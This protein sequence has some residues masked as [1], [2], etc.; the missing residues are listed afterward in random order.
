[1][2]LPIGTLTLAICMT[3]AGLSPALYAHG[4]VYVGPGI[5]RTPPSVPGPT[6]PPGSGARGGATPR[7]NPRTTTAIDERLWETWWAFNKE[8]FFPSRGI[9]QAQLGGEGYDEN[10]PRSPSRDQVRSTIIPVLTDALTSDEFEMRNSAVIALGKVGDVREFKAIEAMLD[11]DDRTVVEA[12]ILGLGLLRCDRA[13]RRLCEV[14]KE[15]GR[16]ARQRGFAV[17]ALG[18]SG[19]EIARRALIDKIGRAESTFGRRAR[20]ADLESLRAVAAGLVYRTDLP[21]VA[22]GDA[23]EGVAALITAIR[24]NHSREKSFLPLAFVGLAKTRDPGARDIVLA[25]LGHRKSDVRGAAAIAL[26]RVFRDP[27]VGLQRRIQRIYLNERDAFVQRLMLISLGRMGG[28]GAASLLARERRHGDRQQRAFAILGSAILGDVAVVPEFRKGL[29]TSNDD[30]LRG[31]FAIAIGILRDRE[32]VPLILQQIEANKSPALRVHLI[33][34]LIL[35]GDRSAAPAVEELLAKTRTVDLQ[36]TAALALGLLGA[37]DSSK[38][39]LQILRE[40]GTVT[41]K[42][43]VAAGLGRMGEQKLI[44]PLIAFVKDESQQDLSRAFGLIALGMMGEKS[45]SIP[46]FARVAIDSQYDLQIDT[47]A[48]LRDIL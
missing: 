36:A 40:N 20:A 7:F 44:E 1:M 21:G 24:A 15:P 10:A 6:P 46:P 33:Q 28:A 5:P 43:S 23:A 37:P 34:A 35:L 27:E 18:L 3:V 4:G 42:G 11:D 12:A 2:R 22:E 8:D 25:G 41:V 31:A 9:L 48:E 38:L 47:L 26:G 14:A 13:E 29:Q 45:P 30:S 39:L 32:S 19:G 16:S 17:M